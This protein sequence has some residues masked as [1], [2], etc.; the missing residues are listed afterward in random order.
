MTSKKEVLGV[1]WS[2]KGKAVSEDESALF[3]S[4][5]SGFFPG[6]TILVGVEGNAISERVLLDDAEVMPAVS[7]GDVITEELGIAVPYGTVVAFVPMK[8]FALAAT[9]EERGQ[10]LGR[11][12]AQIILE[13]LNRGSFP[14]NREMSVLMGLAEAALAAIGRPHAGTRQICGGAF[15]RALISTLGSA[16]SVR[17]RDARGLENFEDLRRLHGSCVERDVAARICQAAYERA[18][19]S[20]LPATISECKK[21]ASDAKNTA[22]LRDRKGLPIDPEVAAQLSVHAPLS[23]EGWLTAVAPPQV[24]GRVNADETEELIPLRMLKI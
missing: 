22:K 9:I 24:S 8:A 6:R 5:L 2:G 3:R 11:V 15:E 18:L 23:F 20:T 7:L 1:L 21:C 10:V 4:L 17:E 14:M 13:S 16:V 19:V 12:C